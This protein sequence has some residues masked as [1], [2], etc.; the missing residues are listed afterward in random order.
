M[1]YLCSGFQEDY[2]QD[3]LVMLAWRCKLFNEL[4][5][6]GYGVDPNNLIGIVRLRGPE[7]KRLEAS[8]VEWTSQLC[9][10]VS[11]QLGRGWTPLP[12]NHLNSIFVNDG[13]F[14]LQL[15]NEYVMKCVQ[16]AFENAGESV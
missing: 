2:E 6:N 13:R 7:L 11:N 9:E 3:P 14:N 8:D 12:K 5:L 1:D 10:E 16:G 15:Q 4:V